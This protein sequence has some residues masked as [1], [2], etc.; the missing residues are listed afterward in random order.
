VLACDEIGEVGVWEE[1]TP[2]IA[3]LGDYG[4]SRFAVDPVN[5]G[6]VYLGTSSLGIWKTTD[7]GASW[8]HIN[9]GAD[10]G[11]D[12]A[13]HCPTSAWTGHNCA[14][15]LDTGRQWTL[16]LDPVDTE[17]LFANN[18]YGAGSAG[19]FK[20]TNGGVDWYEVWPPADG[21]PDGTTGFVGDVRMDPENHLHLLLG[22]HEA[23]GIAQSTDGGESWS[24]VEGWS[25][26]GSW[27]I[28][29]TTWLSAK[30]EGIWRTSDSGVSWNKVANAN[31]A[32]HATGFIYESKSGAYYLGSQE[33][34]VRSEDGIDW[35]V[36]PN[37]GKFV[38]D[39]VGDGNT[40]Y[41]SSFGVCFDYGTDLKP[42]K[43]SADDDGLTWT[44]MDSPGFTQGADKLG[45]DVDH[46]IFY[47]SNCKRG[48]WRVRT[49]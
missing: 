23:S 29:S 44:E 9:T 20:S 43:T 4:T 45:Y 41:A 13:T 31:S 21:V 27:F 26:F 30:D 2:P 5:S 34:V 11:S 3:D 49:E 19:L 17:V 37:S 12:A 38:K 25:G 6:T 15:L 8:V 1:V 40:I 39:I 47:S 14:E 10:G 18:G 33:G 46:H 22:F 7:C 36:I 28:D 48:F 42:Y 16:V 35:A 32:G 24:V